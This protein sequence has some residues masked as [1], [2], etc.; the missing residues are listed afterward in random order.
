MSIL[1]FLNFHIVIFFYIFED[2]PKNHFS[3]IGLLLHIF[4]PLSFNAFNVN[5][6]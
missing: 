3:V 2:T 4:T 6:I 1:R 5:I